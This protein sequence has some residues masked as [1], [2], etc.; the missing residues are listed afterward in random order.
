MPFHILNYDGGL[1]NQL[2]SVCIAY[3]LANK[4]NTTF[5]IPLDQTTTSGFL[6]IYTNN[7]PIEILKKLT[8]TRL[9]KEEDT[10]LPIVVYKV[11][12]FTNYTFD[13]KEA[14]THTILIDGL[15]MLYSLFSDDIPSLRKLIHVDVPLEENPMKIYIGMRTFARENG[16]DWRISMEYYRRA[17][18]YISSKKIPCIID[19]Y[20]DMRGSSNDLTGYIDT[21]FGDS[22]IQVNEYC[23]SS[24]DKSDI[25]HFY[26]SFEYDTFILCNSTFHYWGAIF[27]KATKDVVYPLECGDNWYSHIASPTWIGM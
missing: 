14:Q 7:V 20:T 27:S 4:Y 15:P 19:I 23:G 26:K 11:K 13:P 17:I 1:G 24:S 22:C 5:S 10:N 8:N 16:R 21:Y 2:F 9:Y 3:S 25:V 6:P 12:Q 18:E